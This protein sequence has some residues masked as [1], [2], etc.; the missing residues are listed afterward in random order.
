M[1]QAKETF[2][3]WSILFFLVPLGLALRL[4]I[5]AL[6]GVLAGVIAASFLSHVTRSKAALSIDT[7]F[8]W[9]LMLLQFYLCVLGRFAFPAFAGVLI[10]VP[11]AIFFYFRRSRGVYDL[12]HGYWHLF[13]ALISVFA[14]L[15]YLAG[16]PR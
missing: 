10:F 5:F 9:T 4:H 11:I 3:V 8:A 7:A 13:S 6:A 16:A 2:A 12:N 15:T 14:Q 1:R